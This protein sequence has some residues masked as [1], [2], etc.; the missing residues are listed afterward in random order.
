MTLIAVLL[1]LPSLWLGLQ[2]DEYVLRLMLKEEP[3][4]RAWSRPS[5]EVF[6]FIRGDEEVNRSLIEAGGVPWWIHPR[7]KLAFFRPLTGLIHW[8]DFRIWPEPPWLM[9]VQSLLWFVGAVAAAA[10]R[11]RIIRKIFERIVVGPPSV[12]RFRSTGRKVLRHFGR[13]VA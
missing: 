11:Q 6:A 1:C 5:G 2:V 13:C 3:P 9:L 12:D 7:L 10:H 4:D 8:I